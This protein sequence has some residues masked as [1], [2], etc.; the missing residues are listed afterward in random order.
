MRMH[1]PDGELITANRFVPVIEQLGLMRAVDRYALELAI[2]DLKH[3]ADVR[4]AVN[5]SGLTAAVS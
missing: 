3:H 2:E 4:F 5:I 1:A